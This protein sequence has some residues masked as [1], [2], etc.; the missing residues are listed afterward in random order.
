TRNGTVVLK[1]FLNVSRDEQRKRFLER[2]EDPNKHWKFSDND[3]K[4]REFW[5]DYMNAYEGCLDA[6]ST[7][8][9]PWHIVPADHKWVTR[10]LVATVVTK[11]IERLDLKYPEVPAAKRELIAAAKKKLEAE[12]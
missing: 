4:E 5:D 8:W 1:F 2:L 3:L 6:T 11:A 9:A 10:A 12:E 7:E